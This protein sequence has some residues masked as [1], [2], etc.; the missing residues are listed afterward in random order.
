MPQN[1][2]TDDRPVKSRSDSTDRLRSVED[3]SNTSGDDVLLDVQGLSYSHPGGEQVFRGLDLSVGR[4]EAVAIMGGSGAGKTTLAE[5]VFGLRDRKD[6]HGSIVMDRSRS[7]LMLQEGA[8]LEHLTVAENLALVLR[9]RGEKTTHSELARI[10]DEVGLGDEYLDRYP[11]ELSGGQKRRAAL[12]RALCAHPR[13]LYCDEP[14]AGLDMD[15]VGEIGTLLRRL[16]E[17]GDRSAVVVTH[18]PK[19]AA[20]VADRVYILQDGVLI[21][22]A[23]WRGDGSRGDA[24]VRSRSLAADC[25]GRMSL[26]R[27]DAPGACRDYTGILRKWS[28]FAIGDYALSA[29]AAVRALPRSIRFFRDFIGVFGRT[30]NLAGFSGIPFFA[31]VGTILGATFIMILVSAS[32]LPVQVTLEKVQAVP[33]TAMSVPLAAFLYSARSGSAVSSWLGSM[34]HTRQVDALMSL[35]IS[36][37]EYL[38]APVWTALLLSFILAAAVFFGS[39][40]IGAYGICR[41]KLG[42]TNPAPY[43]HPFVN[44][45]IAFHAMVKLP[46]YA[47]L[48]ASVTAHVGLLPKRSAEDVA[49]G[50]THVIIVSTA[51]VVLVE[52]LFAVLVMSMVG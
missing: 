30:M 2:S 16:V 14:S 47:V 24:E 46:V 1:H 52:L 37:D 40:W 11:S 33:L 8:L 5:L 32:I 19:L 42:I 20:L 39:M 17:Q 12:A 49:H 26:Q 45:Q 13:L 28:P 27:G 22:V 10:V 4:G 34:G 38:R 29:W 35:E 15:G 31:L 3:A 9:R 51:L 44:R 18:D 6:E 43:L 41:Y 21:P 23:D 48:I 7:A 36:P 50:T 25:R